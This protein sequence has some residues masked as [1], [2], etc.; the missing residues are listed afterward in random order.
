MG[1]LLPAPA[2]APALADP[3]QAYD[4]WVA[5]SGTDANSTKFG[6]LCYVGLRWS[7]HEVNF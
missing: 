1:R 6:Y 2:T 7:I 4:W 5:T 3:Q